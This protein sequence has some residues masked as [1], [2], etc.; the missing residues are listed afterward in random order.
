M[1]LWCLGAEARGTVCVSMCE[2]GK[3]RSGKPSAT[4]ETLSCL[5]EVRARWV[6]LRVCVYRAQTH[7]SC[8]AKSSRPHFVLPSV[9]L[10]V[11]F[12]CDFAAHEVC[13]AHDS[14]KC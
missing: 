8:A 14:S 10:R 6:Y 3:S 13:D 11:P 2:L 4:A 1:E 12:A 5:F 9:A 7:T